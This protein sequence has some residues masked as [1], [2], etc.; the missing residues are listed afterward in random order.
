MKAADSLIMGQCCYIAFWLS[1][2]P[3][4]QLVMLCWRSFVGGSSNIITSIFAHTGNQYC[5][6]GLTSVRNPVIIHRARPGIVH[7]PLMLISMMGKQACRFPFH[8]QSRPILLLWMDVT[9]PPIDCRKGK[10][11]NCGRSSDAYLNDILTVIGCSTIACKMNIFI[12][13]SQYIVS[14]YNYLHPKASRPLCCS[15]T[16]THN[17]WTMTDEDSLCHGAFGCQLMAYRSIH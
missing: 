14:M 10:T 17:I 12:I 1:R 3:H 16:T 9:M 11:K 15:A 6:Y 13:D 8:L 5:N 2:M 7:T 4:Q